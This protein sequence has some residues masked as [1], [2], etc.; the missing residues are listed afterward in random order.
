MS[1][2]LFHCKQG[3]LEAVHVLHVCPQSVRV[4]IVLS[5]NKWLYS[6]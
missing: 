1:N 4:L 3:N 5:C 2:G 6:L